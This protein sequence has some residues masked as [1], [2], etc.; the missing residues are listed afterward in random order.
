MITLLLWPAALDTGPRHHRSLNH[1]SFVLSQESIRYELIGDYPTQSF[2]DLNSITGQLTVS[3]SLLTDSLRASFYR[4]SQ[5]TVQS[6]SV[7]PCTG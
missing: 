2:F 3:S 7:P 5:A 6:V 1:P 4:V